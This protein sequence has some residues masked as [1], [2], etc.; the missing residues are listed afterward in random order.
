MCPLQDGALKPIDNGG[1]GHVV[2]ATWIPEVDFGDETKLE[3]I[4]SIDHIPRARWTLVCISV[5]NMCHVCMYMSYQYVH[6]F[7]YVSGV[8]HKKSICGFHSFLISRF[9]FIVI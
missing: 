4:T 8:I 5:C 2:C 9:A 6:G 3:P 7:A 1:W